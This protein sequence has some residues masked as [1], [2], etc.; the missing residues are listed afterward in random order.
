MELKHTTPKKHN[1]QILCY[2]SEHK[3]KEG[4]IHVNDNPHNR[5][6]VFKKE[7]ILIT[8]RLYRW[9][10]NEYLRLLKNRPTHWAGYV[11][12]TLL[13]EQCQ[14]PISNYERIRVGRILHLILQYHPHGKKKIPFSKKKAHCWK[15]S[16][17][18]EI[19]YGLEHLIVLWLPNAKN[20]ATHQDF[21][22]ELEN[23]RKQSFEEDE[24]LINQLLQDHQQA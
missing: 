14:L 15:W 5:F 11:D 2:M 4:L 12:R 13:L 24:I 22:V 1:Q 23:L 20:I 3:V 21:L 7:N 16:H 8:I 17:P 19:I 6:R 10:C 18:L 9:F